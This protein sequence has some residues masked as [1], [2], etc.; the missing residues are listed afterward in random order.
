[1]TATAAPAPAQAPG[2]FAVFRNRG[3]VYLWTAQLVSTIGDAL[4]SLAAGIIVF[5]ETG[6]VLNVGIMLMVSAAPTLIFG[7][8]AG[9]FVDRW[10]RKT[11]MIVTVLVQAALVASIPFLITE[12]NSVFWLYV[13]VLLS[14]SVRQFFDP[15]NDAVLPEVAT[16]EE[17]AAANS[18]MA[19]AQFGSTA[20]GFALAGL[21]VVVSVELVFFIDAAT[22]LFAGALI[23]LVRVPKI[24]V[25]EETTVGDVLRN[26]AFGAKFIWTTPILRSMNVIRIPVMVIFGLQNV[27][28]LPFAL[29]VLNATEFQYG[30]QEGITSVGFVL[31]S[32]LMAHYADRLR[33]GSWLIFSF[34]GMGLA[35]LAYSLT[36]S[37]WVAIGLIGISGI[38][39]APSYVASRLINQ[40][41]TPREMRGRVFSTGYVLRDVFYLLGMGLAGLA[42]IVDVRLMFAVSS[43]VLI[44]V[45]LIGA[46]LP[47]IGQ[48]AAEWRR[49]LALLRGAAAA[50]S[51]GPGRPATIDDVQAL[52]RYIPALAGMPQRDRDALITTGRVIEAEPGSAV[53]RAGEKGDSA[54]F[55]LDGRL[56][57]GRTS[58]EGAYQSLSAMGPGDVL[59]EIAALTGSPRT[60]DVVAA[61]KSEL[62]QVP[63]ETLKQLMALPQFGP[64]V[65][66]KMQERLARS[67]SIG[68]L[69]RFGRLDQQT[70]R[71]MRA[72][73]SAGSGSA[74]EGSTAA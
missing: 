34:L 70:L 44:V 15:A 7:L 4:T 66:G 59:G 42:D 63:A 57:A 33:E 52:G 24:P 67:A 56:V 11:I 50:P 39:N 64:L 65:L 17:L 43:G 53:T 35:G 31:G 22:F 18:L 69:P 37:V 29:E 36:S 23:A 32:L 71:E 47:G 68:D 6:S 49:S 12:G 58:G 61:E 13:I 55:V 3:F 46:L 74:A 72:E 48:P 27:L 28:L 9:V 38:L 20:I 45:S 2:P 40:R 19:I 8:I 62:L 21:L 10:D 14:S 30:L 26:L 1:L 73:S 25:E 41:N 5:R 16:D 51:V 60:A 54:Y